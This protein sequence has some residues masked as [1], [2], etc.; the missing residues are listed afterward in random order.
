M[1]LFLSKSFNPM[2]GIRSISGIIY[3]KNIPK[4]VTNDMIAK[5]AKDYGEYSYGKLFS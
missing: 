4:Y 3:V 2:K 5:T 1:S